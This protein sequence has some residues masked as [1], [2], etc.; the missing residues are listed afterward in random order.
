LHI[1]A[2]GDSLRD[3][4][5]VGGMLTAAKRRRRFARW[6]ETML[7]KRWV[8]MLVG[9]ALVLVPTLFTVFPGF[10]HWPVWL[11]ALIVG[12]WVLGATLA[13]L[14][15]VRQSRQMD[16]LV[17]PALERRRANSDLA[18][19]DILRSLLEKHDFPPHYQ[20]R[21]F[22]PDLEQRHLLSSWDPDGH[23]EATRGWDFGVGVTGV[24]WD[25][26]TYQRA[27]GAECAD[28]HMWNIS[29]D[30]ID[31]YRDLK[32]I[33]AEPVFDDHETC[34]AVLTGSSRTVDDGQLVNAEGVSKH[35]RLASVV[36]RVLSDILQPPMS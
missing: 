7:T 11:R 13:V 9:V 4:R 33:A 6:L 21:L 15:S 20:F 3:P 29:A 1:G 28:T 10:T 30:V 17:Q 25:T 35:R 5:D 16:Q 32:V 14:G 12:V 23:V 34:I 31:R 27:R 19:Q 8:V 26:E 22:I 36:A 18:A 2:P 24:A